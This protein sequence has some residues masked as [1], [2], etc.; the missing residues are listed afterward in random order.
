MNFLGRKHSALCK[1]L[2]LLGGQRG[3]EHGLVAAIL[4]AFSTGKFLNFLANANAAPIMTAH[5]A[6]IRVHIQVLIVIG[7]GGVGIK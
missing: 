4:L 3:A 5:S 7:A 6:E 1:H 2:L